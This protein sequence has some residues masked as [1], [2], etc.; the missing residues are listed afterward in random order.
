M[1]TATKWYDTI[2]KS[3][4]TPKPIVFRVVWTILYILM[5]VSSINVFISGASVNY[6]FSFIIQFGLNMSWT[7]IFFY[8][9]NIKL[10]LLVLILLYISVLW[11]IYETSKISS[12]ST[13][14]SIPYILWLSVAMY[15]N[16]YIVMNN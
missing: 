8:F 16:T 12:L 6:I 13:V 15:L 10:A 9:K 1:S 3:P 5:A 2:N 4:Y 14:L 7:P 11:N